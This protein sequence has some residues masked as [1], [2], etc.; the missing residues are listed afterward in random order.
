[1]PNSPKPF[2]SGKAAF[3]FL[4]PTQLAREDPETMHI[5]AKD[6]MCMWNGDDRRIVMYPCN[7]NEMLNFVC[8]HPDSESHADANDGT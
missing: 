7:Q 8:I 4:I 5:E 6:T 3:R 2:S 1:M